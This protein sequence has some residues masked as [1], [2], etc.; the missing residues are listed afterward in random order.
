MSPTSEEDQHLNE[1][2]QRFWKLRSIFEQD[3]I[4]IPNNPHLISQLSQMRYEF[5][6]AGKIRIV[7]PEGK[8]PDF[9]DSLMLT[10]LDSRK[11][12]KA[13]NAS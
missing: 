2:S 5:T 1:K 11:R 8:S 4:G 12:P 6:S 7:D 13:A 10:L 9:A 3:L